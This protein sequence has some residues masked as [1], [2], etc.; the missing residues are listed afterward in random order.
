MWSRITKKMWRRI[1]KKM[2]RRITKKMWKRITKKM[3]RRK[4]AT[5]NALFSCNVHRSM[6]YMSKE[7]IS[8]RIKIRIGLSLFSSWTWFCLLIYIIDIK[9]TLS[10]SWT[11][12]VKFYTMQDSGPKSAE[13]CAKYFANILASQRNDVTLK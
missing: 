13:D 1:T 3:W 6:I 12:L 5:E 9:T 2:W 7:V 8:I 4:C 10:D 11:V